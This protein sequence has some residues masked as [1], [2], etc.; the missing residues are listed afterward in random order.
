M[1]TQLVVKDT[2]LDIFQLVDQTISGLRRNDRRRGHL[3]RRPGVNERPQVVEELLPQP[4]CDGMRAI[5]AD[6]RPAGEHPL[7]PRGPAPCVRNDI[8]DTDPAARAA[9]VRQFLMVP[10][11]TGA[12]QLRLV[13]GGQSQFGR[14]AVAA[15]PAAATRAGRVRHVGSVAAEH[16]GDAG[17]FARQQS[18]SDSREGTLADQHG[19]DAGFGARLEG[20]LHPRSQR[21]RGAVLE[22]NRRERWATTTRP[23]RSCICRGCCTTSARSA[24]AT[25]YL[26]KPDS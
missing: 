26:R 15:E 18:R 17:G 5:D 24:S 1:A 14:P 9:G 19:A 3:L 11:C 20:R 23:P 25:R 7:R 6:G 13:R 12:R 4:R 21:T 16:G 8:R 22:A 10:I 2:S